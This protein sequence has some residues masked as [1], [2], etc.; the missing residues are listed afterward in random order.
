MRL[1]SGTTPGQSPTT[2]WIRTA[3]RGLSSSQRSPTTGRPS[4]CICLPL[5]PGGCP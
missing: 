2:A 4:M 3:G 5:S 1:H